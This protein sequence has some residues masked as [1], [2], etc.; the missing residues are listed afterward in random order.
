MKT[1]KA[2]HS[3]HHVVA[4]AQHYQL[5]LAGRQMKSCHDLRIDDWKLE[6]N[7]SRN[8]PFPHMLKNIRNY[9]CSSWAVKTWEMIP[10]KEC[11]TGALGA[12]GNDLGDRENQIREVSSSQSF[13][14]PQKLCFHLVCI[15]ELCIRFS[16]KNRSHNFFF[17][18]SLKAGDPSLLHCGSGSA[19]VF[20][21]TPN[22]K[23]FRL[24][25]PYG[26]CHNYSTWPL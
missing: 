25:L 24:C 9:P 12:F 20:C 13:L 26:L 8:S 21:K 22:C 10:S 6:V 19:R 23:E 16:L 3:I 17:L 7:L 2:C 11:H 18:E 15:L 5:Q 1:L 4:S 14:Q